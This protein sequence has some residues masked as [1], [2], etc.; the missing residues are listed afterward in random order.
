MPR[1]LLLLFLLASS[2]CA[3]ALSS[4]Q[5]AHVA[6]RGHVTAELGVDVSAPVGTIVRSIDAGKT[7][8]RAANNRSL[9]DAER[10]QLIEAG[11]NVALDP[12]GVVTHA[13]LTFVP[14]TAWELGLRWSP[15]TWRG[16]VRHQFLDQA[17]HGVDLS[18]GLGVSHYT[19]EFPIND[20]IG[21]VVHLDDFSRWTVDIPL[22]VG[23]HAPWYRLWGGPRLL[24]SHFDTALTVNLPATG[25]TPAEAL[26]A[27]VDGSATFLG[28]QGGVAV[29]YAHV[30]LGVELTIVQLISG[31]HLE[32]GGQRQD[33]DLG[34][35][36]ISPGIAL[37][38]EF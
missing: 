21:D 13:G 34:G 12:P 27:S 36:V 9:T 1:A 10:R 29:G 16:A 17:S 7:L 28:A 35:P 30:F 32:L 4:F 20:I 37:M 25:S 11:A 38:G 3:A 19:F 14:F 22:V 15:G 8:A 2:G 5:P 18:A 26:V 23:K 33:V 6:P 24:F 31:A